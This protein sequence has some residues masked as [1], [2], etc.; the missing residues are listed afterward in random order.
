MPL[1]PYCRSV[2]MTAHI[3]GVEL[4]LHHVDILQNEQFKPEFLALNP[5]HTVPVFIDGD[6][7]LWESRAILCYLVS[8]Y[9]KDDKLYPRNPKARALVDRMLYFEMGT[10]AGRFRSMLFASLADESYSPTTSEIDQFHEALGYLEY[11]LKGNKWAAGNHLTIADINL[12]ANLS[13]LLKAGLSLAKYPCIGNWFKQCTEEIP[14]YSLFKKGVEDDG[15]FYKKQL[16]T[17]MV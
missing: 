9:G 13:G 7:I 3:L 5:E 17:V 2:Q 12:V 1:S 11:Y 4:N 14:G 8:A 15:V 6:L 16:P 10:I